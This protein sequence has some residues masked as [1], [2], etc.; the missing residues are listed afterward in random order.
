MLYPSNVAITRRFLGFVSEVLSRQP[1][2][3]TLRVLV[4][5]P[6]HPTP[7][8]VGECVAVFFAPGLTAVAVASWA[9]RQKS[10]TATDQALRRI[11]KDSAKCFREVA[12]SGDICSIL[13]G[14]ESVLTADLH[15]KRRVPLALGSADAGAAFE[16]A[17]TAVAI[18][19]MPASSHSSVADFLV[20][21]PMHSKDAQGA[22][23]DASAAHKS[24]SIVLRSMQEPMQ[25]LPDLLFF[26]SDSERARRCHI[27]VDFCTLDDAR[28]FVRGSLP[29]PVQGTDVPYRIS[30][31]A[32][33][34]KAT[35]DTLSS[36]DGNRPRVSLMTG[37]LANHVALAPAALGLAVTIRPGPSAHPEFFLQQVAHFLREEQ[38]HGVTAHRALQ[39][40]NAAIIPVDP[41]QACSSESSAVGPPR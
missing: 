12:G 23:P 10:E 11:Y 5:R 29:L 20:K 28:F 17:A 36:P 2:S 41:W 24:S 39:Y 25:D 6:L 38:S 40:S 32:E 26:L 27:G 21:F 19:R 31:W 4:L 3:Q 37:A 1:V 7:N 35:F 8:V 22:V 16:L 13:T 15:G 33:V 30:L 9:K 18:A 34:D 14:L